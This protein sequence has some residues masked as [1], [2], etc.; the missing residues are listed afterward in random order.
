MA[1]WNNGFYYRFKPY[2]GEDVKFEEF[3]KI[4]GMWAYLIL[5]RGEARELLGQ[6][7]A[8]F[9]G[10]CDANAPHLDWDDLKVQEKKNL[11]LTLEYSD[12]IFFLKKAK[13]K[14]LTEAKEWLLNHLEFSLDKAK[15]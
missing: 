10:W 3:V 7:S 13:H 15:Y 5:N 4:R 2:R 11:L 12:K 8:Y 14:R 9:F 6:F 1:N